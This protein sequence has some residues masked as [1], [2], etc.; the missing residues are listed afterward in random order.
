MGNIAHKFKIL[1]SSLAG[2]EGIIAAV[3]DTTQSAEPKIFREV[4]FE[5]PK[6]LSGP[7]KEAL[8]LS[9]KKGSDIVMEFLPEWTLED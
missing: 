4:K 6:T 8:H 7:V 1:N 9:K 5:I 2:K 3:Y